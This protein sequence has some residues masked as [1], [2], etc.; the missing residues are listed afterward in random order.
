MPG[1][2]RKHG[3]L[4]IALLLGI[5]LAGLAISP[6]APQDLETS[7]VQFSSARAMED[8]RIIAARPHPTGSEEIAVVR[9]YLSERLIDLGFRVRL[10]ESKLDERSLARLNRWSGENKPEQRIFNV[11]GRLSGEDST[12]PA[13]LL[14]AHYDTVWGSPGAA[15]DTA[16]VASIL[17]IVRALKEAGN[18]KRELIVL[19]TDAEELG[20]AGAVHFFNHDPLRDSIGAVINFEARGG[21]G[22]A[23]MFQTSAENGDAARL[24]AEVVS[25]P[26]ASSLS[27]FVYSILPNDTDLTPALEKDYMAF[28]IANIGGAEYYH[29][30]GIDVEAL[31]EATV[32]HMG[33]QGLDLSLALLSS[34]EFPSKTPDATFFDV[35]GLFTIVYAPFWGWLILAVSAVVFAVTATRDSI[36]KGLLS[37]AARMLML[38]VPGALLLY[39]LNLVSGAGDSADYYDRL[40][41]IPQLEF[42]AMVLCL[43][44]F[45]AVFA[46]KTLSSNER[47]G[48]VLPIFILGVAGQAFAP[49]ATYFISVPLLL[50]SLIFVLQ[51]RWPKHMASQGLAAII[52]AL[53]VGYMLSL[54]HLLMLGVGPDLLAV[55]VLPAAIAVSAILPMLVALPK[56]ASRYLAITGL[57]VSIGV[58]LW[59]RLDPIASTVP[60]Y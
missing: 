11:I 59:I 47:L 18:L 31:D 28:N 3:P 51:I 15:D 33:S 5:G 1:K 39:G 25:Q 54:G 41:A 35:F 13:L 45:F 40:A 29:S 37:G 60:L 49:T 16:G 53:V 58:A 27:T 7:P 12:L 24:Y 20:L 17:E 22:T 52:T 6:P 32:Q 23:N 44:V 21:G 9:E 8:I 2:P 19:F 36:A 26:S 55:A 30:P 4:I 42:L 56:V 10:S 48:A 50:S 14:M 43:S 38:L 57:V 34:S 46:S